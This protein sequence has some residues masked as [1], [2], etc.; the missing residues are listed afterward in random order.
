M[1]SEIITIP[2]MLESIN[3]REITESMS[4]QLQGIKNV[5][6]TP[7]THNGVKCNTATIMYEKRGKA[8]RGGSHCPSQEEWTK[9]RNYP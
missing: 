6:I 4:S 2:F 5:L 3:E 8:A 9:S 1:A 7:T